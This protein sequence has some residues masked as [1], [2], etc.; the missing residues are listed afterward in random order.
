MFVLLIM[1]AID[2]L[3]LEYMWPMAFVDWWIL[4]YWCE[5]IH[6]E[7]GWHWVDFTYI[8]TYKSRDLLRVND[9]ALA[10]SND[11]TYHLTADNASLLYAANKEGFDNNSMKTSYCMLTVA[12]TQSRF[13][14]LNNRYTYQVIHQPCHWLIWHL[15]NITEQIGWFTP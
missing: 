8:I 3:L 4:Q 7:S 6:I 1:K 14:Y 5:C 15:P 12:C 13:K 11:I 10:M 9:K 2:V